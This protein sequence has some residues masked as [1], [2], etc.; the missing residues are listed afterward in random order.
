MG[1]LHCKSFTIVIYKKFGAKNLARINFGA[2]KFGA[3]K[4]AK[5]FV[6]HVGRIRKEQYFQRCGS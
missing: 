4:L 2:K 6:K 5:L 1:G 3:K